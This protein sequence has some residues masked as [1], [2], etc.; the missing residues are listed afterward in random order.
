LVVLLFLAVLP[1][2]AALPR[3]VVSVVLPFLAAL[4][5]RAVLVVL[6]FLAVLSA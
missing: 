3:W 5:D 1:D 2:R 4:P 6:P